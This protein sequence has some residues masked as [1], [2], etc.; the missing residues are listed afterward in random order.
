[1]NPRQAYWSSVHTNTLQELQARGI[2][3]S[4]WGIHLL[5]YNTRKKREE[6]YDFFFY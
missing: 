6:V 4:Q 5:C 3:G 2:D 1:M